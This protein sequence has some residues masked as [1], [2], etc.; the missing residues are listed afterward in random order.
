M[1]T[2]IKREIQDHLV[3]F[4]LTALFELGL[5]TKLIYEATANHT[6]WS[7]IGIPSIMWEAF[8]IF[9]IFFLPI[10]ATALGAAQMYSDKNKK[11][12]AFL[13]TLAT[14][15]RQILSARII[16]GL[17][18]LLIILGPAAI[19]NAVLLN[20]FPR[21]A[22]PALG[23][24]INKFTII[25][26]C[27]SACYAFGLQIGWSEKKLLPALGVIFVTAILISLI[28]IK[29]FHFQTMLILAIFAGSAMIR[30]WQKFMTTPI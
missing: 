2:L 14:T 26:L 18:W 20:I 25:F 6:A 12:S 4:I 1:L 27:L 28:A 7:A 10:F 17:L 16:T 21:V 22:L 8:L 24:L 29:G 5:I 13:S 23:L 15:R 3:F 19:T 30:T 9:P 11:I